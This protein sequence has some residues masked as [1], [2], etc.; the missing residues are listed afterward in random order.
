MLT[1]PKAGVPQN[2]TGP[3]AFAQDLFTGIS[4]SYDFWARALSFGQYMG[5]RRSLVSR[6]ATESSLVLD[7]STGRAGV[8]IEM[9]KRT[10]SRVVGLDVTRPMLLSGCREIDKAGLAGRIGLVQGRG[11]GLPFPD[12]TFDAVVFTFLLRYVPE[13]RVAVCEMARVLKPGGQM[14]S[15][16]FGV[17]A[18]P[19]WRGSWF[20][21]TRGVM[22]AITLPVSPGWR[23]VGSFLGPSI[24][25]FYRSYPLPELA[26]M[27]DRCGIGSVEI[28]HLSLGGAVVM[29]GRKKT[30]GGN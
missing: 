22:P 2:V 11:E 1:L 28:S 13:P 16:E 8:A 5:W 24:S 19:V 9:A 25:R 21:Y 4:Q 6:L 23:R 15:L 12:A 7:V 18:N 30:R 10:R 14:L 3:N 29:S 17:P 26:R 27:W 20:L